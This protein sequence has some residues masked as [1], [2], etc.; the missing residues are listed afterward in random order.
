MDTER[1]PPTPRLE[2]DATS[3]VHVTL[4]QDNSQTDPFTSFY[5][6]L[7]RTTAARIDSGPLSST[8]SEKLEINETSSMQP[9]RSTVDNHTQPIH[10]DPNSEERETK[11]NN[12]QVGN[13]GDWRVPRNEK[14]SKK[15]ITFLNYAL[16]IRFTNRDLQSEN[17]YN[18]PSTML[19]LRRTNIPQKPDGRELR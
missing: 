14:V 12:E 16:T 5:P 4:G 6:N 8:S 2:S 7:R 11:P 3:P 18:L 13:G 1:V 10:P 15:K 19:S 9:L 17:V